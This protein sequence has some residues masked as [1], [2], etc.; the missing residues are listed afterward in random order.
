MNKSKIK[1]ERANYK[2]GSLCLFT[3]LSTV[4]TNSIRELVVLH[5]DFNHSKI[6]TTIGVFYRLSKQ[7]TI[8]FV[9]DLLREL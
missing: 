9:Q 4:L 2:Y 6:K 3:K 1:T 7:R 8:I 5:V